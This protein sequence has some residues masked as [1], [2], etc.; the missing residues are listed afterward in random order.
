MG[1]DHQ[2]RARFETLAKADQSG[3]LDEYV[4]ECQLAGVAVST[5]GAVRAADPSMGQAQAK[6]GKGG[7]D[8]P[9]SHQDGYD[10]DE[11][12]TPR[13]YVDAARD[14]L[15]GIGV[16]PASNP[17]AQ[18]TVRAETFYTKEDSGLD[19]DWHGTVWLNPPYS[20]PLASQFG[21]HLIV[22][23]DA[24]HVTAAIMVQN[25]STDTSWFHKLAAR[26]HICLTAG[27]INFD[28]ADGTSSANRYGQAFFY[29]GPD[30]EK[31]YDVFGKFGLVGKL[32]AKKG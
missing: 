24:G 19:K 9:M 25:A 21:D 23:L 15:G 13:D 18:N 26:G 16:D 14:V 30:P 10:S 8:A 17:V 29:F 28:R 20:Q 12:Y 7:D 32:N 27:R 4:K 6:R 22:Q 5:R 11:W 3:A 1:L 31:F 2:E